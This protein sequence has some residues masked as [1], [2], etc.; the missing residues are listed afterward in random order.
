MENEIL[1]LKVDDIP[2]Y[3]NIS[4]NIDVDRIT[5]GIR[6]AQRAE[7]RR[8]LG[9]ELYNKILNDFKNNTL[10]GVYKTIYDNYVIDILVNYSAY[11]IVLFNS[12]R[13]DNAGNFYYEPD[14]ARSADMEDSEKIAQRYLK[15]GASIE[16]DFND[17]IKKNKVKEYPN[18]GSCRAKG[19]TYK[20]NWILD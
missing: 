10:T 20:L 2:K 11:H 9:I 13:V 18:S 16:L 19:N 14:N 6:V 17:W 1:L 8:I 4:G 3:T 12:L 7:L 5:V 15:I